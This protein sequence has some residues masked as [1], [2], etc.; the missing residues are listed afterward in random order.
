MS[1]ANILTRS[2]ATNVAERDVKIATE[3]QG[4]L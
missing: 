1:G 4:Q 2:T 3:F